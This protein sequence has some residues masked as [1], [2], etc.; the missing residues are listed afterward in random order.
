MEKMQ[1]F[2]KHPTKENQKGLHQKRKRICKP[3][4]RGSMLSKSRK[5]RA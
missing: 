1:R 2:G 4:F 3:I 5:R